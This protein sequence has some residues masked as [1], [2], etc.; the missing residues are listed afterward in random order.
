MIEL[1]R[2]TR[3]QRLGDAFAMKGNH[4]AE[5]RQLQTTQPTSASEAQLL[6][7]RPA[8]R[9]SDPAVH[10]ESAQAEDLLAR[11]YREYA[12]ELIAGIRSRFGDGPPDPEDAA[13]A[14][15]HQ[16]YE[17]GNYASIR[18]LRAYLWRTARNIIL[19]ETRNTNARANYDYQIEQLYFAVQGDNLSPENVINARQQLEA[20]NEC[21]RSMPEKRRRAFMLYRVEQLT[22]VEVGRRL[23]ISRT[24]VTKH[25]SRAQLQI[26]ALFFEET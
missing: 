26:N 3:C 2:L 25:I 5:R 24:A 22:L 7:V 1:R 17:R 19:S 18:N 9:A 10:A 6:D 20:I 12:P 23:G 14:A 8:P 16:V 11:V 21:L 4:G 15:F 13:Q